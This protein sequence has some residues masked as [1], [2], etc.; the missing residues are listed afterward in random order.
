MFPT[1]PAVNRRLHAVV[2]F[3]ALLAAVRG[4][5]ATAAPTP[6]PELA[7]LKPFVGHWHGEGT[8]VMEPGAPATKWTGKVHSQW[9]LS[10]FFL[11]TDTEIQFD[12]MPTAMRF[13][14]YLGWDRENKRYANL[15]INNMGEG[16]LQTPHFVGDD[17]MLT[18]NVGLSPY[19]Q[20]QC[21]RVIA[22]FGGDEQSISIAFMTVEGVAADAVRGSFKRVKEVEPAAL[23]ATSAMM[24]ANPHM[25]KLARTAGTYDFQGE[26]IFAPGM[27]ATKITGRDVVRT[28][29]DGAIVYVA[30]TGSAEGSPAPY[31]AH[32][33]YVWDPRENCYRILSVNNMGEI[34]SWET[35][36]LGDDK[37]VAVHAG[38]H[39]GMPSTSRLVLHLDA[40]GKMTKSA[41]HACLGDGEPM[42]NFHGTYTLVK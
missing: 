34:G 15:A 21:E 35:R 18:L 33:F 23:D 16:A 22:K 36:L 8:A 27:P 14:E 41:N 42:R 4:Q 25:A 11:Q 17:T 9:A 26:M 19:G 38:L 1:P 30:T 20:P 29:F 37:L 5:D 2:P 39:M 3:L 40:N 12:G 7:R 24:P 32:G 31:E 13:R 28:L 10:G 6:S